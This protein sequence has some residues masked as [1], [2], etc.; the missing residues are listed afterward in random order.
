MKSEFHKIILLGLILIFSGGFCVCQQEELPP[1]PS[2]LPD[3]DQI[4]FLNGKVL[5]GKI[6][7]KTNYEF[8]FTDISN[9][10]FVIDK[11]RVFSITE[12]NKESIVY[13]YDTLSGNFLKVEDMK[14]F[15]YGERDA[16]S[17][18][19]P[20]FANYS[21]LVV[22]AA[23][24]FMMQHDQ[25]FVYLP[26]PLVYTSVTLLFPTK[27]NQKRLQE[28]KYIKEDEYLRGYERIARSKRT[29]SVL[30]NSVLG[31]IGGYLIG[32]AVN[33]NSDSK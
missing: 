26:I 2:N 15:V 18:Y 11:Y 19:K 24:G 8:S 22:G 6:T 32:L 33:G 9:K 29:Q 13:E 21:A 31:M 17:S 7:N 27:V 4:L 5:K 1:M 14:L 12:N 16:Y 10:S 25:S 3:T 30:R 23:S 28:T 20:H